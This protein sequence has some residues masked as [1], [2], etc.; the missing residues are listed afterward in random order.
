[1]EA[2]RTDTNLVS[3]ALFFHEVFVTLSSCQDKS[4]VACHTDCSLGKVNGARV[5]WDWKVVLEYRGSL[6]GC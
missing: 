2:R 4:Y 3:R 5:P 1:M 6:D